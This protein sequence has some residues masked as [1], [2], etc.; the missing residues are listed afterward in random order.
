MTEDEGRRLAQLRMRRAV[1]NAAV[2]TLGEVTDDPRAPG[3]LA[4]YRAQLAEIDRQI[5]ELTGKPPDVVVGLKAAILNAE[6]R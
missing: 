1:A 6:T 5:A 3:A 2:L 4:H